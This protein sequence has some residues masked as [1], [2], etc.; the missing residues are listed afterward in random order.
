VNRD[1]NPVSDNNQRRDTKLRPSSGNTHIRIERVLPCILAVAITSF[2]ARP[3][4]AADKAS[5]EDTLEKA[6][7]VLSD[8]LSGGTIRPTF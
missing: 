8:M 7:I 1:S 3:I 6:N 5:D 2:L 4:C